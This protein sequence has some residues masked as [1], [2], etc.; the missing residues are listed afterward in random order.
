MAPVLCSMP[1]KNRDSSTPYCSAPYGVLV[2]AL[3]VR[4]WEGSGKHQLKMGGFKAEA[5]LVAANIPIHRY[6]LRNL[7]WRAWELLGVGV[8][9]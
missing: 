5:I 1:L 9:R 4:V 7:Q 2:N 8:P 6:P 3:G